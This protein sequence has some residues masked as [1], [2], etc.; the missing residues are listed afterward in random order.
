VTDIPLK[1]ALLALKA[2]INEVSTAPA[3]TAED[4]AMLG[5]AIEKIAG[6]V[7][8][9][10]FELIAQDLT[11]QLQTL[12]A[13]KLAEVTSAVDQID[14]LVETTNTD[15]I[16]L[17]NAKEGEFNDNTAAKTTSFNSNAAEKLNTFNSN[18]AEKLTSFNSN[19]T[20]K[21]NT[22]N[23]Q[24]TTNGIQAINNVRDA[25]GTLIF[26]PRMAPGS[27]TKNSFGFVTR[28]DQG[29]G[30]VVSNIT[31]DS[32]WR[33]TSW[34]ETFTKPDNSQIAYH[35]NATYSMTGE[36][37]SVTSALTAI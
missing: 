23:G 26:T 25:V 37:T 30:L 29:N 21:L 18:A 15:F 3:T 27:I 36:L 28:W 35:Y 33:V 7:S 19:A 32:A 4:L 20:E 5:T 8:V 10:E 2:K 13:Q 9:V 31:Y 12:A 17:V 16:N 11:Q 1:D 6:R 22:F 14:D 34:D 24:V